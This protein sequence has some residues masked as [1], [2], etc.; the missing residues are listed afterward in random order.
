MEKANSLY[1][2]VE[3]WGQDPCH[4]SDSHHK[5]VAGHHHEIADFWQN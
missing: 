4:I 5:V 3:F 1:A 2:A